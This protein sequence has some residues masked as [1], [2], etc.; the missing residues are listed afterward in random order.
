MIFF[1]QKN[2][3]LKDVNEL[4]RYGK[5]EYIPIGKRNANPYLRVRLQK[6]W[7]N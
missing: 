2:I 3:F 5:N 6:G 4:I 7:N 1:F